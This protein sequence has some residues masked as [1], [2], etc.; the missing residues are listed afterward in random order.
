MHFVTLLLNVHKL[1]QEFAGEFK[2]YIK[3]RPMILPFSYDVPRLHDA[4]VSK[5]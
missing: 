4:Q 1:L 2:S 5:G 3:L